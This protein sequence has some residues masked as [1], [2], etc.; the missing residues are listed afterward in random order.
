RAPW[1]LRPVPTPFGSRPDP[2]RPESNDPPAHST[3]GHGVKSTKII[4]AGVT[5]A[6]EALGAVPVCGHATDG[7]P[8]G[9]TA[10]AEQLGLLQPQRQPRRLLLS[11]ERGTSSAGH[12]ARCRRQGP[13]I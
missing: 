12:A 7:N 8:N 5:V 9:P 13:S 6:V 1:R 2:R 10:I 4:H 3:F 11:S